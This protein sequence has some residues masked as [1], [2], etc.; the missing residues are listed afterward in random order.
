MSAFSFWRF[1]GLMR[2]CVHMRA[3]KKIQ[4]DFRRHGVL[5]F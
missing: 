4:I 1:G 3:C 5:E 2:V